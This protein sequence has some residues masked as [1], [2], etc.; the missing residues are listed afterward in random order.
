LSY[1]PPG[2]EWIVNSGEGS[3]GAFT[4]LAEFVHL[5]RMP[6]F[7]VVAG[8]FAAM[9][10]ARRSPDTWLRG[11]WRRFG[12]PLVATIVTLVPLMNLACELSNLPFEEALASWLHNSRTS[13]GYWIRHLWFVIVLLYCSTAA[14]TLAWRYPALR[15]AKL[16]ARIDR[17]V[18]R[19]FIGSML[20][21]SAL[22]G[23]WEAMAVE[24]FYEAGLATN[25]PQ[26]LLRIDELIVYAPYFL[27]GC[28]MARSPRTLECLGRFSPLVTLFALGFIALSLAFLAVFPPWLGRLVG[29]FTA[30]AVTQVIIAVAKRMSDRPSAVVQELVAASFVI[31]LFHMPIVVILVALAAGIALPAAGKAFAIMLLTFALSYAAWRAISRSPLL[32]FAFNGDPL[33]AKARPDPR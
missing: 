7:F 24:L 22:L 5:F 18:S 14:A 16:P 12:A 11:R 13:A 15:L 2:Q 33:P 31:Y 28:L 4:Y 32:S 1:R 8:Y 26:E 6:A 27:L 3:W 21:L 10:L 9:L 19:H 20:G 30:V 17:W 23:L 25:V 29:A